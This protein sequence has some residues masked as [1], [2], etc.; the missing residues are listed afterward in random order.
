VQEVEA[1]LTESAAQ[2]E[3]RLPADSSSLETIVA[4][5][6]AIAHIGQRALEEDSLETL[7]DEAVQLVARVLD[8]ELVSIAELLP[9]RSLKLI[10]GFGWRPGVVGDT[11]GSGTDSMAGYTLSTGGPVIVDDFRTEARFQVVD[12]IRHH[13][14]RS[15]MTVRIGAADNPYGTLAV[16]TTRPNRF[17]HDDANFI[18]AVANVMAAAIERLRFEVELR[19]SRDQLATIVNTI[20]EGITVQSRTGLVFANDEGARLAGFASA[21]EMLGRKELIARYDIFDENEAPIDI[22]DLPGRRAM[23]TGERAEA[24][25]GFRIHGNDDIR[26]SLVRGAAVRGPNGDVTHVVNTFRDVTDERFQRIARE[27]MSDAVAVLSSTLDADEAA[28]RLA[29][30]SVPRLADY[31]TVSMVQPD[32]SINLSALAHVNPKRIEMIR[33]LV[34]IRPPTDPDGASGPPRVIRENAVESGVVTPEMIDAI[35]LSDRQRELLRGLQ[36]RSYVTVP[37]LGRTRPIGALTLAMAESGRRLSEREVDLAK[38]LG[39]RAGVA[40]EN[41]RL[42]QTADT[43][44]SELDAVLAALAEAV[45]VF[46]GKGG[47]RLGNQAALATFGGT[48]PRT[49]DELW[50]RVGHDPT[51]DAQTDTR[52]P[53]DQGIELE[54]DRLGRWHELRQYRA[55]LRASDTEIETPTVIVMRDITEVRAARAARDAFMGVLSHELRTPITTIYG[56]SELLERGLDEERRSEVIADIRAES[57]RLARLVEDLLVMTRVE[58]GIVEIAD[59]PILLQHLLASVIGSASSR[60]PGAQITFKAADR[61]PAVRGDATYI[62]QVVR[63]LLTNAVRYGNGLASGIDVIA[64]DAPPTDVIVRVRDHGRGFGGEEPDR[65][66]ELF[67]RSSSARSVPGGAGIGLFVCRN[68]I[69][70]MGGRIWAIDQPEGGAE[71]GFSLPVVEPDAAA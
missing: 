39:A 37:L 57:E 1:K 54:V 49:L 48:L 35:P 2:R 68:L 64:E 65:L 24:V 56:G 12:S 33:E 10:A 43:R 60:W 7:L 44:R 23:A 20:D 30:L 14:A 4:Q 16:L 41:A 53:A 45:L 5:Q 32:G 22:A 62:E 28:Q 58:R 38:E 17:S 9:D 50:S 13:D 52:S 29:S 66:F 55:A 21:E 40:L 34:S 18:L 25:L 3:P 27:Y 51:K 15:G 31:V 71:F 8:A 69:E 36:L 63:N 67:Y 11:L 47:L 6:A 59:E 19:A 42:Y 46:D 61:L 70:K 26:W